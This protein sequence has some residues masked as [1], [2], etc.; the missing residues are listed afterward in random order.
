MSTRSKSRTRSRSRSKSRS[1]SRTRSRSRS[2]SSPGSKFL[3]KYK[4]TSNIFLV[5]G[6]G[7]ETGN[8]FNIPENCTYYTR[9]TCGRSSRADKTLHF[10]QENF[11][12][13]SNIFTSYK[14]LNKALP[15]QLT[16]HT[17]GNSVNKKKHMYSNTK[18]DLLL[19]GSLNV[20]FKNIKGD[21]EYIKNILKRKPYISHSGIIEYTDKN[22]DDFQKQRYIYS[23]LFDNIDESVN[24]AAFDEFCLDLNNVEEKLKK[25]Y[26]SKMTNAFFIDFIRYTYKYSFYPSIDD[27]MKVY[28][29][30]KSIEE[31]QLQIRDRFLI[32]QAELFDR[33]PGTYYNVACREPCDDADM[34]KVEERRVISLG[35]DNK[36]S[37]SKYNGNPDRIAKRY[38]DNVTNKKVENILKS[39]TSTTIDYNICTAIKRNKLNIV[40]LLLENGVNPNIKSQGKTPLY[41]AIESNTPDIAKLLLEKGADPDIKYRDEYTLLH[42]LVG[43]NDIKLIKL[44]KL[45]LQYHADP[46]LKNKHDKTPLYY[47]IVNKN[48]KMVK[49]LLEYGADKGF[50]KYNTTDE[51]KELL[52]SNEFNKILK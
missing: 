20:F 4:S 48:I 28:N 24:D 3:R 1:K 40:K 35:Y 15:N 10:I 6:H 8:Q 26:L 23:L 29:N 12:K 37:P 31:L 9:A 17:H 46:N 30:P 38:A 5:L 32:T 49:L 7:C 19:Y 41:C 44:I 50:E 45:L 52:D 22:T 14:N 43:V 18:Y 39:R 25:L 51:I 42:I 27:V 21:K 36:F 13:H 34:T 11:I 2:I 33:F 47:A 16:P